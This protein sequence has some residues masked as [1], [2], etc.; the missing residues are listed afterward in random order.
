MKKSRFFSVL[1]FV[2]LLFLLLPDT[3]KAI[4]E[5]PVGP[6]ESF[7][8]VFVTSQKTVGTFSDIDYYNGF[9]NDFVMG[10]H[11]VTPISGVV[12]KDFLGEIQW[13]AIASTE[14]VDAFDNIGGY[15]VVPVYNPIGN[16]VEDSTFE[17][18]DGYLKY[19]PIQIN[20]YGLTNDFYH[21]WTGTLPNG[22]RKTGY[23][24]GNK[25]VNVGFTEVRSFCWID[26]GT[27]ETG[28]YYCPLY[29]ISEELTVPALIPAPGSL[30]LA[31]TGLLSMLGLKRL[32]RKHQE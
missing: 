12:G 7:R 29:A 27:L 1:L 14:D 20:E 9:I 6:G 31:A 13:K 17:M 23:A 2:S 25:T 3:A 26:G 16:L 18:F 30:I 15:S 19:F 21:A 32:R 24:M 10:I 22:T 8:W 11:T 28:L 4:W 5:V